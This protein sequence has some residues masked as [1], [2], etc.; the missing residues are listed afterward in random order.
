ML[1]LVMPARLHAPNQ[2]DPITRGNLRHLEDKNFVSLVTLAEKLITLAIGPNADNFK[3]GD[4]IHN[5]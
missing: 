4:A 1:T 5:S 3:L 2:I